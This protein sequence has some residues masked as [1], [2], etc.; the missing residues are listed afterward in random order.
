RYPMPHLP[1]PIRI[2]PN[3]SK[4]LLALALLVGMLG[5]ASTPRDATAPAAINARPRGVLLERLTWMEAEK[6][7]T[8]DAVVVIALGAQAK[9]HG[10]HLVLAND[11]LMAEYFKHRVLQEAPVVVAPTLNYGYYPAFTGYPGSTSLRLETARDVVVDVV[12]GLAK[13]GPRRF[14]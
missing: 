14:Y 11:F 8:R 10:P 13:H 3:L 7:L 1:R 6:V 2:P 4:R 12:R 5:C 9:E